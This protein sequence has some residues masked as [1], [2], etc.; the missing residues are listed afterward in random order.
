MMKKKKLPLND[1]LCGFE[2]SFDE[3]AVWQPQDDDQRYKLVGVKPAQVRMANEAVEGGADHLTLEQH[4][5]IVPIPL[6][7]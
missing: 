6:L 3:E 2:E 7:I 4:L 5:W 1:V